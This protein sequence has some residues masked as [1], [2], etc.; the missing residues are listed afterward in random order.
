[1]RHEFS[2]RR[3]VMSIFDPAVDFIDSKDIPC[4]NWIHWLVRDDRLHM[5]VAVRSNDIMWGFSGI[6]AF[7]W[8]VLHELM[9]TW[10][11]VDVGEITFFASSFHLYERHEQRAR[12]IVEQFPGITCSNYAIHSPPFQTKWDDFDELLRQWFILES[13]MQTSPESFD[14]AVLGFPD[15][16]LRH[17]LLL[18]QVYHGARLALPIPPIHTPLPSPPPPIPTL[19]TTQP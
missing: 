11:N 4:N 1:M 16:L 12:A 14:D 10:L 13:G 7:E 5:N 17:F 6:N 15:P 18:I 2:T 19:H 3:A 9:A 8:S